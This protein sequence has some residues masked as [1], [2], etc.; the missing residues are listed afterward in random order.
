MTKMYSDMTKVIGSTPLTRLN[1]IAM[2]FGAT[3]FAKLEFQ[4][5]LGSVKDRIGVAMI[6]AAESQGLINTDTTIVEPTSGNTGIA[7]AFVCA[8]KNYD[9]IFICGDNP[10]LSSIINK[11]ATKYEIP[12]ING[13]SHSVSGNLSLYFWASSTMDRILL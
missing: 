10:V 5:P 4:N 7:L 6:E 9:L 12:F 2:G 1:R 11:I 13:N 8:A 3:I